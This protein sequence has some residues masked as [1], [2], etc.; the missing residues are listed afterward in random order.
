M[1]FHVN[2]IKLYDVRIKGEYIGNVD[3]MDEEAYILYKLL[4]K[5]DMK[6]FRQLVRMF[7]ARDKNNTRINIEHKFLQ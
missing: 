7:A 4:A 2:R 3:V 6:T 5:N 1:T